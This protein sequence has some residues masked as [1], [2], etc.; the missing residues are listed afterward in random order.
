MRLGLGDSH[1]FMKMNT[2]EG[3]CPIHE[4]KL[5]L[6]HN[7]ETAVLWRPSQLFWTESLYRMQ[8]KVLLLLGKH[9]EKALQELEERSSL[10]WFRVFIA[11]WD[12]FHDNTDNVWRHVW[13]GRDS[14]DIQKRKSRK[15]LQDYSA[16]E[17]THN[18]N[19]N[20]YLDPRVTSTSGKAQTNARG[21]GK[22]KK[23]PSFVWA[24]E[25]K[26]LVLKENRKAFSMTV[27][28][29]WSAFYWDAQDREKPNFQQRT[30]STQFSVHQI[31]A[32]CETAKWREQIGSL[33]SLEFTHVCYQLLNLLSNYSMLG[34]ILG[35]FPP[36][37]IDFINSE[38]QHSSFESSWCIVEFLY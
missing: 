36:Y 9:Y 25:E 26:H 27:K 24:A 13:G 21:S 31:W 3:V 33:W 7:C 38:D 4:R 14:T 22:D 16:E 20:K 35:I 19:N 5:G 12:F 10:H 32:A 1:T 37:L 2:V 28:Q 29:N 18:N 8:G 34:I 23:T 15:L 30:N 11:G 6:G 17:S